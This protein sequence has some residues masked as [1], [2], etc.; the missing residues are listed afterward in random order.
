MRW[1]GRFTF[2]LVT[3]AVLDADGKRIGT[4]V[5]WRDR[6]HE[7]EIEA[8]VEELVT[9][10]TSG[11]LSHRATSGDLS[12]RLTLT[13]KVG[14]FRRHSGHLNELLDRTE[15]GLDAIEQVMSALAKGDLSRRVDGDYQ[16]TFG[17]LQQ[18]A[19]TSCEQIS[20]MLSRVI[21]AA[22]SISTSATEI[23]QGNADLSTRTEQQSAALE[24][25]WKS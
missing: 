7:A 5:E 6:T 19:N 24:A 18:A 4:S 1:T 14:F 16:G 15:E 9:R 12:H 22:R 2:A 11:D 13:D 25:A 3:T 10:A 20:A 17:R 23:A 21:S 8:E